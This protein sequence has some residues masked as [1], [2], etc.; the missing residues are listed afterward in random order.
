MRLFRVR[1]DDAKIAA[2]VV[3][4]LLLDAMAIWLVLVR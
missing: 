3:T 2:I 1:S 4:S